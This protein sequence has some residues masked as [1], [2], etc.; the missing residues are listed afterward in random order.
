MDR[1]K[2]RKI[3]RRDFVGRAGL[4]AATLAGAGAM[5]SVDLDAQQNVASAMPYFFWALVPPPSG[6]LPPLRM[7]WPPMS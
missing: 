6:T 7:P 3:S 1:R 5:G 4:G 2:S